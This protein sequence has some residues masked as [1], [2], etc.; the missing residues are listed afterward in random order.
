MAAD[1]S[2]PTLT[3]QY[4][5]L[6][7]ALLA[8]DVDSATMF[9]ATGTP[10]N[11]PD[12]AVRWNPS[13]NQFEQYSAS[14]S[15]WS[16]MW[17]N[18]IAV[19]SATIANAPSAAGH[20]TRKDYVD[21][22]VAAVSTVANAALPKAGGTMTGDIVRSG[23][24]GTVRGLWFQTAGSNRWLMEADGTAESGSNAGTNLY[25]VRYS[26]T[27]AF[28]DAPVS[29]SRATGVVSLT[30]R[31][32]WAGVT[33]WDS[34]NL[35]PMSSY[36]GTFTGTVVSNLSGYGKY[37][38]HTT[39]EIGGA[40]VDWNAS[41]PRTYPL[42]VD[43]PSPGNAYGGIRWTQWGSRHIAAI[44]AYAGG[45]TSSAPQIVFQLDGVA[46][47]WVFNSSGITR[48]AGGSVYGTWNLN[49][50]PVRN[51]NAGYGYVV[52]DTSNKITLNWGSMIDTYV[53]STYIGGLLTHTNFGSYAAPRTILDTQGVG[54]YWIRPDNESA[55]AGSWKDIRQVVIGANNLYSFYLSQRVA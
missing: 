13:T 47:A 34:G 21:N 33:P 10:T 1:W 54:A 35:S 43:A 6:L 50:V 11:I 39:A 44:D 15:T 55:P 17:A 8:R 27:A 14:G 22:A 32:S 26:D 53:D 41:N 42:Q 40:F 29:I 45:T 5:T 31:P 30:Q 51:G 28:I 37:P 38:F 9:Q 19:P 23:A 2:Q 20:A 12:K 48:G 46:T 49:P 7:A 24:A 52:S 4:A 36:G 18:G 16:Q 3:T 25:I